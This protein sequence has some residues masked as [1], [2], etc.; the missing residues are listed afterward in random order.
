VWR[1]VKQHI[2]TGNAGGDAAQPVNERSRP[3]TFGGGF[4][5][6][7]N[8]ANT[9]DPR[10]CPPGFRPRGMNL[11]YCIATVGRFKKLVAQV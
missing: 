11:Q 8:N 9:N 4:K 5:A 1:L 10:R 7:I 6:V 3:G 2:T